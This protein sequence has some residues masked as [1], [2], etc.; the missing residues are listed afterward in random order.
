MNTPLA[1]VLA[2]AVIS[3]VA[4]PSHAQGQATSSPTLNEGPVV[5]GVCLISREAIFANAKVGQ[6]ASAR[7]KQLADAAEAEVESDRKPL[8]AEIKAFQAEAPKLPDA[9][10]RAREQALGAKLQPVQAKAALRGR[11]IEATRTKAMGRI[12]D[13]AQPVIAQVF[14]QRACGLLL[15]RNSVLAGNMT[16]D[17]TPAVVQGLDAKISTIAFEREV[18]PPQAA[19]AV[20]TR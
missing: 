17:L 2:T 12:A 8:D 10:R 15:D 4:A 1:V 18:L 9:Q 3:A 20:P 6:A 5:A 16:N 7:L 19:G 14:K 11:E 13:A